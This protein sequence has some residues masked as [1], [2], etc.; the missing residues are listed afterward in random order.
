MF[1]KNKSGDNKDNKEDPGPKKLDMGKFSAFN[2]SGS[3][4]GDKKGESGPVMS[5][6]IKK[7]R[8]EMLE[9]GKLRSNTQVGFDPVL[10]Q[11]KK[12]KAENG[13]DDDD[14]NLS[15]ED[16]LHISEEGSENEDNDLNDS[17]SSKSIEDD[18]E[19]EKKEE[20][21]V[22]KKRRSN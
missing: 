6:A 9:Q 22:E 13:D 12:M 7:R 15:D 11:R 14:N 19:G 21:K 2:N 20:K 18:D 4:V 5:D 10:E 1:D 8:D 3:N 17:K 16:D